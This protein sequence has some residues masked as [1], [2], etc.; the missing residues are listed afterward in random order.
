MGTRYWYDR[1]LALD[2]IQAVCLGCSV[3]R[4]GFKSR[5][6]QLKYLTRTASTRRRKKWS[7]AVDT[8][9]ERAPPGGSG[10]NWQAQRGI[11]LCDALGR[12]AK[13]ELPGV[14]DIV[15]KP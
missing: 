4:T 2:Q 3:R 8:P 6:V 9:F 12:A 10:S 15:N 1:T 14:G 11:F 7:I 5:P 13:A